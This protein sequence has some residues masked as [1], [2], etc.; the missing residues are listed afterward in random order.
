MKLTTNM[1]AALN[2]AKSAGELRRVHTPG[3]G[4]PTWP[5]AWQTLHALTRH[6]LLEASQRLN[7]KQQRMQ[8]WTITDTG[9]QALNPPPRRVTQAMYD[10]GDRELQV[11]TGRDGIRRLTKVPVHAVRPEDLSPHHGLEAQHR[12]DEARD[13]RAQANAMANRLR[14]A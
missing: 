4:T 11:V 14:A 7:R 12:W 13:R 8:V 6:G 10:V 1:R 3:S 5:F 2:Q 9:R